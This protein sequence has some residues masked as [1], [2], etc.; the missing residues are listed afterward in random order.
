MT[1]SHPNYTPPAP[2]SQ[3]A[4][5]NSTPSPTSRQF[6]LPRI[7]VTPINP[8]PKTNMQF[9]NCTWNLQQPQHRTPGHMPPTKPLATRNQNL[10]PFGRPPFGAEAL[11]GRAQ[12]L[13]ACDAGSPPPDRYPQKKD[14][15]PGASQFF[16]LNDLLIL[17]LFHLVDQGFKSIVEGLF[18]RL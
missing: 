10:G 12:R 14:P 17:F 16:V 6:R 18:E 8:S 5:P 3:L 13:A 4:R 1:I 9:Y 7:F 15:L 2:Y 11:G